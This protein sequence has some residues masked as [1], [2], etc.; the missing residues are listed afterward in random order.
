MTANSAVGGNDA[1]MK[2]STASV[3]IEHEAL[4]LLVNSIDKTY[5]LRD[6]RCVKLK[7]ASFERSMEIVQLINEAYMWDAYF[8]KEGMSD[9]INIMEMNELI[10]KQNA[11]YSQLCICCLF[12]VDTEELVGVFLVEIKP[13][14]SLCYFGLLSVHKKF[15][16]LGFGSLVLNDIVV[17][18]AKARRCKHIELLSISEAER[19]RE[20]Y[21]SECGFEI[22]ERVEASKELLDI[23]L[24]GYEIYFWK[25]R[26]SVVL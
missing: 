19:L 20:W 24:D 23:I 16:G 8:K 11:D 12:T 21:Q 15:K 17:Q 26:K 3:Q 1:I 5:R 22:V 2:Q 7:C 13:E 9:R 4:H 25:M 14:D 10:N 6:E 18:I